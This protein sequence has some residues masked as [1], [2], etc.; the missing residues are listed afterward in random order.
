MAANVS[1]VLFAPS[2]NA[3]P[4]N[5][6]PCISS[7]PSKITFLSTS[8]ITSVGSCRVF[9]SFWQIREKN[10]NGNFQFSSFMKD[11]EAL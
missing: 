3:F 9:G 7:V 6:A 1:S 2:K 5:Y 8:L 10:C 4:E 11:R